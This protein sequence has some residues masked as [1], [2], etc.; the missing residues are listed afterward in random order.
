MDQA[1][2]D[3]GCRLKSRSRLSQPGSERLDPGRIAI[4]RARKLPRL[5]RAE[6]L[7]F[8]ERAPSHLPTLQL[9]L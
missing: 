2:S 3:D 1:G 6:R 5:L 4:P 9:C 8:L 7:T